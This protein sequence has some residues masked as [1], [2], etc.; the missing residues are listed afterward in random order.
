MQEPE[1]PEWEKDT[2]KSFHKINVSNK[3]PEGTETK[4]VWVMVIQDNSFVD[5]CIAKDITD[6]VEDESVIREARN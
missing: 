6:D 4:V 5:G 3:T 1:K 2:S